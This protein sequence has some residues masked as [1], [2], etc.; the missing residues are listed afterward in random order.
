M[1]TNKA[2]KLLAIAGIS[3]ALSAAYV[4]TE[5]TQRDFP[6]IE[7]VERSIRAVEHEI[8][9]ANQ[10]DDL[11]RLTDTWRAI[12]SIAALYDVKVN[13]LDN[14]E[15]AGITVGDIPGG[16]PWY[17]VL[18]GK[19][20]NVS[21]ASIEIQQSVPIVFGAAALDNDLIGMSF[22]ALGSTNSNN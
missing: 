20:K 11:P 12:E 10:K 14:A 17:G 13:T 3:A 18:Q 5:H 22:A 8:R 1:T 16:T 21:V 2:I 19:A 6:S 4:F 15:D 9:L 7:N